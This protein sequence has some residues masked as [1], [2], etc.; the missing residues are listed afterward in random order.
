MQIVPDNQL[1]IFLKLLKGQHDIVNVVWPQSVK[2]DENA[3]F[4]APNYCYVRADAKIFRLTATGEIVIVERVWRPDGIQI[5]AIGTIPYTASRQDFRD[6]INY[7]LTA[8]ERGRY[9]NPA[10]NN[11]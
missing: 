3:G 1:R 7:E 2:Y 8:R 11:V 4:R 6:L 10:K 9:C 5:S